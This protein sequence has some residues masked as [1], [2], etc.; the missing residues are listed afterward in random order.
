MDSQWLEDNWMW[1]A[2][3]AAAVLVVLLVVVAIVRATR[4]NK[5]EDQLREEFRSEYDLTARDHSKTET[6]RELEERKA[7]V[8]GYQVHDLSDD[9]SRA[10]A[11]RWRTVKAEFVTSPTDSIIRADELLASIMAARG[12]D[13]N[14][15]VR[16]R[17]GDLSVGHPEE[18]NT[19]REI[20]EIARRNTR[21]EAS[22]EDL[23]YAMVGY[24]R[25]M[26]SMLGGRVA[27]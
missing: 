27:A 9:Q 25:L 7:R 19:Y 26:E 17:A 23:R 1:I 16:G 2:A 20:T 18:A 3:A 6:V 13:V 8:D 22:T 24:E 11:A 12:Y 21:G 10:F 15:G 4:G 5:N 14:V